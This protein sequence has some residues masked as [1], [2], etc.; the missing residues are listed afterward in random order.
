MNTNSIFIWI[1]SPKPHL[2]RFRLAAGVFLFCRH[3]FLEKCVFHSKTD[4]FRQ[5]LVNMGK[6]LAL[7]K[8]TISE[9]K[10]QIM[11]RNGT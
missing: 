5:S 11:L 7:Q 2:R 4:M 9:R 10:I 6:Y 3:A 8:N 1:G